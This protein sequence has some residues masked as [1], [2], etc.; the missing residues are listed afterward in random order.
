ME[1]EHWE[2]L[3]AA[4]RTFALSIQRL[5]KTVGEPLGLAYLL[6]RVSDYLEDNE[7]MSSERKV[8][9]LALWDGVLAGRAP[10]EQLV[11]ELYD[12]AA[13]P[14]PDAQVARHA[15][16]L[17]KALHALPLTVQNHIVLH[18]RNSTQGMARWVT[19]GPVVSNEADMDDYMHE[20]AGRVGYLS[21]ELFAW[22]SVFIRSR[23]QVLMP[24]ARETGL[25]LQTVN[26]IR[27]LRKDYERGWIYVP[28]SFCAVVNLSRSDLFNPDYQLQA[29]QV[30]DMLADKAERHLRAAL[31]YVE[32]LPRWLHTV[33]LACIWPMLFAVRTLALSRQNVNVLAGEVKMTRAEV[34]S[35]VRDTTLFGWSNHWL[36][37]YYHYLQA[38]PPPDQARA[39]SPLVRP[40]A[41]VGK[42]FR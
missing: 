33:R 5:P 15:G 22:Y 29:L 38:S 1:P 25:A 26:I 34:K 27:G 8:A 30:V 39:A 21:T 20:V 19:R 10:A 40:L 13:D 28:E 36:E 11:A 4:S 32:A 7:H 35:I 3:A 37:Y 23:V 12:C 41:I 42:Y 16:E 9:L 2:L 14:S 24:L 17:V 6:L 18:V 31:A